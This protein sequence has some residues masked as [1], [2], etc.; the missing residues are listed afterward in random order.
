MHAFSS[1]F[2]SVNIGL[3][4]GLTGMGIGFLFGFLGMYLGHRRRILW[5]ET[6]RLALEKGQPIPPP[7]PDVAPT[8]PLESAA[9]STADRELATSRARGYRIRGYILGGL[10]NLAVGAGL[11]FALTQVS[12]Q[13]ATFAAIPG[14]I[15]IAFLAMALIEYLFSRK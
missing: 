13:A 12:P 4:F 2:A 7:Y 15:G 6:A 9:M 8:N 5:H 14:F 1:F 10:I 11:Y 3:V